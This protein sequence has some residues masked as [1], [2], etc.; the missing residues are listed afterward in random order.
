MTL[1]GKYTVVMADADV[2]GTDESA[3]QTRHW[4]VNSA[5]VS[6]GEY[7]VTSAKHKPNPAPSL[8]IETCSALLKPSNDSRVHAR[9]HEF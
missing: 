9:T 1:S 2:V 5:T 8:Q 3:G 7:T 6:D 4:L